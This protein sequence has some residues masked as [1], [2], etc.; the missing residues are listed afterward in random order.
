MKFYA[1]CGKEDL[2][3]ESLGT[4]GRLLFEL[5][6]I[7]GAIRRCQRLFGNGFRLYSY[8]NFYRDETFKSW[9]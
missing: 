7:A 5:K 1:Y 8:T 2:G 9:H 4:S 3:K 6:T